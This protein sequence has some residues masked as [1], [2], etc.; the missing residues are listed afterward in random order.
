MMMEPW[1]GE[2]LHLY[3]RLCNLLVKDCG[4]VRTYIYG[5]LVTGML[6]LVD[7]W[8]W[9]NIYKLDFDIIEMGILVGK[10]RALAVLLHVV[11]QGII[12]L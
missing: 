6:W 12:I 2:L 3:G 4:T 11:S 5:G 1:D 10:L 7:R 9:Y 8:V